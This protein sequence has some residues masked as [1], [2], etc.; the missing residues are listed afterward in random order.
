[1]PGAHRRSVRSTHKEGQ[2]HAET[3]RSA[4][5]ERGAYGKGQERNRKGQERNIK[6][7]EHTEGMPGAHIRSVRS[8]HKEGQEHAET[9]RSAEKEPGAD[10]KGQERNR[11]GQERNRKGQEHTEGCLLYTSDAADE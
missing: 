1:M 5:K 4:E 10:G 3:A 11:K 9:A 6:G 8:T 7:Q 2:E